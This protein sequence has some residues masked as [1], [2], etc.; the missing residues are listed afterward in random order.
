MS[1]SF[2]EKSLWLIFL[3][4]FGIFAFYF[5]AVLPFKSPNLEPQ[6]VTAFA[7]A[8]CALVLTQIAGHIV[9]AI[10]D[11]RTETDERDRAIALKGTRNAAYVLSAGVFL[12]LCTALFIDGNLVFTHILLAGWVLSQL[13]EYGSQL[14][15]YRRG[16]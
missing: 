8:L 14:V 7:V 9:I 15:L 12:T 4:L 6:H 11:H 2:H 13:V 5:G 10:M 3:S 16:A 1:L